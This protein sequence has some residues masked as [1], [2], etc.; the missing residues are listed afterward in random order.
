MINFLQ[1]KDEA[2]SFIWS[3]G[4]F[5]EVSTSPDGKSLNIAFTDYCGRRFRF[6]FE[7]IDELM[8]ADPAYCVKSN[9]SRVGDIKKICLHVD[10]GP[11]LSFRY[12]LVKSYEE[13]VQ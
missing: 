6:L 13:N 12:M 8:V 7:A 3:D 2:E 9:H 4:E 10:D 11:V 1:T 5:R